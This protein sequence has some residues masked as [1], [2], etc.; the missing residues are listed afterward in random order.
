MRASEL[1]VL[2]SSEHLAPLTL[3]TPGHDGHDSGGVDDDGNAM[4]AMAMKAILMVKIR[5]YACV[6]FWPTM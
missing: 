4:M 3:N 6:L 1:L 2:L 5:D